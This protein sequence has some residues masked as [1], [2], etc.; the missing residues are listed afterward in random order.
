MMLPLAFF[1]DSHLMYFRS[2]AT[3]GLFGQR[4]IG[5]CEVP[6][7]T[8]VGLRNPN[9]ATNAL[10]TFREALGKLDPGTI[11]V[12]HLGE[13]DCGFVIWYR[14]QK[15][16]EPVQRQ[17]EESLDAYFSFVD[18]ALAAGISRIIV[19]GAT[20]PTIRDGQNWGD[21]ANARREVTASLR[22]RTELTLA[23]NQE[24]RRRAEARGLAFADISD[25]AL[26]PVTGVIREGMRH[27]DPR[28][29]HLDDSLAGLLWAARF[30]QS[31][32]LS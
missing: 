31:G 8:A 32:L 21:V 20:L 30:N 22:E 17:V 5:M 25:E 19:T 23:Y 9:S 12:V 16:G 29:H 3:R 7:A 11:L 18:D 14:A 2:A 28:N 27:P 4:P 13:V 15:Y 1:G 24:L 6:G 26:D 10:Q